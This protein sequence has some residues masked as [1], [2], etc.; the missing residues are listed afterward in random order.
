MGHPGGKRL[1]ELLRQQYHNSVLCQHIE[2]IKCSDCQKYKISGRG[3][4]LL[5]KREMCVAPWEEVV[6]DLIRPWEVEDGGQKMEF[7][8][9]QLTY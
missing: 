2:Q 4:G 7:I 5:S 3:Y 9:P 6:I 8:I 1:T